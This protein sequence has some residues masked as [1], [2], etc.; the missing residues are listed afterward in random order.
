MRL[1]RGR[2]A[3]F[4]IS[5]NWRHHKEMFTDLVE[6]QKV[7]EETIGNPN[8]RCVLSITVEDKRLK[9]LLVFYAPDAQAYCVSRLRGNGIVE[10]MSWHHAKEQY[11][12]D[13]W[14]KN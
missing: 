10:I 2:H 4:G 9:K 7:L 11:G 6:S 8:A 13:K 5:Y 12:N 3:E 14:S 1:A